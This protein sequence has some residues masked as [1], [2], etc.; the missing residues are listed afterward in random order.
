MSSGISSTMCLKPN[1]KDEEVTRERGR[2]VKLWVPDGPAAK[3]R[4]ENQKQKQRGEK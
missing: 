4:E 3:E 1:D 2:S